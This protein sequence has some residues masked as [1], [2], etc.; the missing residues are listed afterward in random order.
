MKESEY[1]KFAKRYSKVARYGLKE[2][3]AILYSS[4]YNNP[5]YKKLRRCIKW[6]N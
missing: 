4:T 1:E 5:V 6:N 3:I 2:M